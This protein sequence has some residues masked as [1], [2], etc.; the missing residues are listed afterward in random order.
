MGT[1]YIHADRSDDARTALLKS[2]EFEPNQPNG[3]AYLG[4]ISLQEGDGV[5]YVK[6]Q[7]KALGLDPKDHEMHGMLAV[8]LYQLGLVEQG[9]DL[10]DGVLALAPTSA[11]AYR[12][13]L[14]RAIAMDDTEASLA[15]ARRAVTDNVE[16]RRFAWG[17]AV[18]YLLRHAVESGTVSEEMAWL[19]EQEP[20]IFEQEADSVSLKH[21]IAQGMA[22]NALYATLPRNEALER[23]DTLIDI[24]TAQGFDPM[25]DP[26]AYASMLAMRGEIEEAVDIA[27]ERIFSQSV[28]TNPGWRSNFSQPHL[29]EVV[30]DP[31]IQAAMQRWEKE[32]EQ[33]RSD[34]Q[35][36]L[37]DLQTSG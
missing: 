9:D 27:L 18:Q 24:V 29:A 23:M 19:D 20:G 37:A 28:A 21:R 32:E 7:L 1:A 25:Q 34:V 5:A 3:Y 35:A 15:S 4:G 33:L 36:Y 30:T 6:Y 14:L 11:I 13:E 17:G 8:F 26:N 2:V 12:T 16:D 10:R 22:I 31:R